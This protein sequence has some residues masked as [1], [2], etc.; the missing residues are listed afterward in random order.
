[1]PTADINRREYWWKDKRKVATACKILGIEPHIVRSARQAGQ[2]LSVEVL[3]FALNAVIGAVWRD[4]QDR[5]RTINDSC[6]TFSRILG[7]IDSVLNSWTAD[8]GD[9]SESLIAKHSAPVLLIRIVTHETPRDNLGSDLDMTEASANVETYEDFSMFPALLISEEHDGLVADQSSPERCLL[10]QQPFPEYDAMGSFI[11]DHDQESIVG[12]LLAG[13]QYVGAQTALSMEREA[14]IE[15]TTLRAADSSIYITATLKRALPSLESGESVRVQHTGS[16]LRKSKR[17]QT[18]RDKVHAALEPLLDA[19]RQK[20][21]AYPQPEHSELLRYLEYPN[22]QLKDSYYLF[23]FLYL[24]IGSWDTL[25]DFSSQLQNAKEARRSPGLS[26]P[27][28]STVSM[29]FDMMCRLDNE[30]TICILLK[31]YYAIK[32]LDGLQSSQPCESMQV[33]TPETLGFGNTRQRGN[34]QLRQ[35]AAE[36]EFLTSKVAPDFQNT[37]KKY[38]S[39]YGKV[40]RFR[41]LGKRLQILTKPFGIGILA[42]LPSGPSFPGFSLTDGM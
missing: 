28:P 38:S 1:M 41:Q 29:A 7:E 12:S 5:N 17:A 40:K 42:L 14:A 26:P 15:P 37:S 11:Q 22:T 18:E 34:P 19:E 23:R 4:C 13:T 21:G 10:E 2:E 36:I 9:E 33:E 3:N 35:E 24:A 39:V 31:W 16:L 6:N 8:S 30:K 27:F 25:A 32:F 20:I